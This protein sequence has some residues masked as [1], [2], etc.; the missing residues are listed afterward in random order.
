MSFEEDF[1]S[2]DEHEQKVGEL[3]LEHQNLEEEY[4][5]VI[6]IAAALILHLY[7]ENWFLTIA[8]PIVG[9]V[10]LRKFIAKR[11]F[12]KGFEKLEEENT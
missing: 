11:L 1:I 8:L 4:H 7:Y 9:Y 2:I 5:L 12:N 10:L 3:E 6:S